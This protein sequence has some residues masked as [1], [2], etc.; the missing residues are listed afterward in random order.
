MQNK[1]NK[2][3]DF[4]IKG[5]P[6]DGRIVKIYV[7]GLLLTI[8]CFAKADFPRMYIPT[9]Q[10][11][12]EPFKVYVNRNITDSMHP[13]LCLKKIR[14]F[15]PGF[16]DIDTVTATDRFPNKIYK[17]TISGKEQT[18]TGTLIT[19]NLDKHRIVDRYKTVERLIPKFIW[20]TDS[21]ILCEN[22]IF[23]GNSFSSIV[24]TGITIILLV[25]III[26][27]SGNN[28]NVDIFKKTLSFF[29]FKSYR[30][31]PPSK[32]CVIIFTKINTGIKVSLSFLCD[33]TGHASLSR[34]QIFAWTLTI[35]C[36]LLSFGL[37]RLDVLNIPASLISLMG[38]T[39]ASGVIS[40]LRND[41]EINNSSFEFRDLI[42]DFKGD[43]RKVS[44]LKIQM[45]IFTVSILVVFIVKCN[46]ERCL[47]DLPW[48]LVG[49]M[50]VSQAGYVAPKFKKK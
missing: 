46:L 11:I 9:G 24:W 34:A 3:M 50:G 37:L 12:S 39:I 13:R 1:P 15:N 8:S 2:S 6:M 5:V 36:F 10:V 33:Q 18:D 38:M 41:E 14:V 49:L 22:Y 28:N 17:V 31:S 20:N 45:L 43:I 25:A 42:C 19:F 27:W 29:N 21:T 48:Q 7:T 16:G 23:V 32:V 26:A 35:A 44:L 30:G 47:W 40:Y 4:M